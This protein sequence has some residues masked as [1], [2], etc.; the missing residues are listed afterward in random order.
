MTQPALST[1]RK[2][3]PHNASR[4]AAVQRAKRALGDAIDRR[5]NREAV[6]V[7]QREM[8][9]L[10]EVIGCDVVEA[11]ARLL[12]A[13]LGEVEWW[14]KQINVDGPSIA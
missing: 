14:T 3:D 1:A 6:S 4:G 13:T 7:E 5:L 12:V 8:E 9:L 11:R 2:G 10:A